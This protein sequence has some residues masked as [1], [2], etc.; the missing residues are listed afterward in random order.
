MLSGHTASAPFCGTYAVH[1]RDSRTERLSDRLRNCI[2][3]VSDLFTQFQLPRNC[4]NAVVCI[5]QFDSGL[6]ECRP[7][8]PPGDHRVLNRYKT[9]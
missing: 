6:T 1:F 7:N 5:I 9:V 4:I 8:D 3:W 2:R